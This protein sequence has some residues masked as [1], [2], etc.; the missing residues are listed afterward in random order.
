M[1]PLFVYTTFPDADVAAEVAQ[2]LLKKKL[3]A[4]A[5]ILPSMRSLYVW[6]G[7]LEDEKESVMILKTTAEKYDALEKEILKLHPYDIPCVVALPIEA[8]NE[9]YLEWIAQQTGSK[10]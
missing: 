10:A 9:A 8:G 2:A 3:I 6:K 7:A 4:C 1:E 5:N